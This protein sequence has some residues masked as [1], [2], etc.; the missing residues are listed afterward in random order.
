MIYGQAPENAA[1]I[2]AN[3]Y[4][5]ALQKSSMDDVN[6]KANT[7]NENVS[8]F[9]YNSTMLKYKEV[10]L[11]DDTLTD[12]ELRLQAGNDSFKSLP[13]KDFIQ[14]YLPNINCLIHSIS[15]FNFF[16]SN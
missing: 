6:V 2:N 13:S 1:I 12:G 14:G 4:A 15:S 9:S 8:L 7:L 3:S 5:P 16:I 11:I 10:K